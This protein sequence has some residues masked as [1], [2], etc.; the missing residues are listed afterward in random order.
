MLYDDLDVFEHLEYIAGLHGVADW[1]PRATELVERLGLSERGDDLPARFS[2][3]LRQKVSLAIAFIR[4]FELLLVDEP[5]VGLDT[6][7]RGVFCEL[8][9]EAVAGGATAVIATHLPG[10]TR[11]ADS[12]DRTGRRPPDRRN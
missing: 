12:H 6:A 3:G 4:P 7:G 11:H 9:S 10:S 5:F 2:R 1:E 8:L